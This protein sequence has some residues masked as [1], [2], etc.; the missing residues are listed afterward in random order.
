MKTLQDRHG[1]IH[2]LILVRQSRRYTHKV[3]ISYACRPRGGNIVESG[4]VVERGIVDCVACITSQSE[5][6]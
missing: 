5:Q 4:L 1:L 6:T 2:K 3:F